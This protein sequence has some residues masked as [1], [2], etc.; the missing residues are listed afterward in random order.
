MRTR[1]RAPG[2]IGGILIL[3]MGTALL[4]GCDRS[5]DDL[6]GYIQQTLQ[7]SAPPPEPY[8]APQ[9][10]PSHTY[11]S[12]LDRDPFS[13]LSFVEPRVAA[14]ED[15]GPRPD[16]NRRREELEQYPL[17]A[18]RMAGTLAQDG[19][20]WALIRDPRGTVHRVSEG[21]YLGQNHGRIVAI[22]E[23]SVELEELVRTGENRW[24]HRAAT[25]ASR[26]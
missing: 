11:P 4:A 7:R 13:R 15:T 18:L 12:G 26:E 23:R 24:Q 3:V 16:T 25:L 20:R 17:D 22:T 21:N 19:Q 8:E 5:T 6:Y 10:L 14:E 9:D 1:R 2:R